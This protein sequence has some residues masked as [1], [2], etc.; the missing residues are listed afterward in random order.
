VASDWKPRSVADGARQLGQDAIRSGK[1]PAEK[2]IWC[3][4]IF[5]GRRGMNLM[6]PAGITQKS[7]TKNRAKK[8]VLK[9]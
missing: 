6:A 9:R 5:T 8:E 2:A 7:S 1:T 3:A 4:R